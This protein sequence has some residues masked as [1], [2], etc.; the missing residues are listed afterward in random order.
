MC[1][2]LPLSI[3]FSVLSFLEF[4]VLVLSVCIYL[5]I[6]LA[7]VPKKEKEEEEKHFSFLLP[8]ALFLR[9][10][11]CFSRSHHSGFIPQ[12]QSACSESPHLDEG[13]KKQ[14]SGGN[15]KSAGGRAEADWTFPSSDCRADLLSF[16]PNQ[17]PRGLGGGRGNGVSGLGRETDLHAQFSVS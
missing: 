1:I 12:K 6:Y 17:A 15:C 14:W 10:R 3:L 2:S 4:V 8:L 7:T 13:G 16:P 5:C 9:E 11:T